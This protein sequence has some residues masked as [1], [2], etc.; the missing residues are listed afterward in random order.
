[1]GS[2]ADLVESITTQTSARS[3]ALLVGTALTVAQLQH[4]LD[5]V[6]PPPQVVGCLLPQTSHGWVNGTIPVLGAFSDLERALSGHRV[7]LVLV[8][9][10]ASMARKTRDLLGRI[11]QAGINWRWIP[12]LT[13]Q[14]T[15]HAPSSVPVEIFEDEASGESSRDVPDPEALSNV[16]DPGELLNRRPRPN[17][18]AAIARTLGGKVVLVTGAG[19]SVGGELARRICRYAPSRLVLL[20]RDHSS[21]TEVARQVA[22]LWPELA[23]TALLHDVGD[24]AATRK[25]FEQYRPQV[26]F[27]AAAYRPDISGESDDDPLTA[28]DDNLYATRH[29]VEAAI[30]VNVERLVMTSRWDALTGQGVPGRT[31]RLAERYLL[32]RGSRVATRM[33]VVRYGPVLGTLSPIIAQWSEQLAQ[34]RPLTVPDRTRAARFTTVHELGGLVL[35]CAALMGTSRQ[36]GEVVNPSELFVIDMGRP[37][38]LLDLARRFI[39][40]HGR[41]PDVE[42]PIAFTGKP[43]AAIDQ[44]PPIDSDAQALP[45]Q[46]SSIRLLPDEALPGEVMEQL[47]S[48]LDALRGD[49]PAAP[50]HAADP[51]QVLSLLG[52]AEATATSSA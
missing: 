13:D 12:T 1:M 8:S 11:E 21:L 14:I 4:M 33:C 41:A 46:H 19:G 44:P 25:A 36:S 48:R 39:R 23:R 16:I 10:P 42:I 45:T 27:H 30:A 51:E 37:V 29:V 31:R 34:R 5:V 43:I 50:W 24:A 3:R 40:A 7:D 28:L 38:R 6:Q 17:D 47:I 22:G 49:D 15:G 20:E 9:L 2:D 52:E 35:Q 32:D 26:V 18:E